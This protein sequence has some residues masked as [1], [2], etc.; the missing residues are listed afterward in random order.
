MAN[1]IIVKN[2]NETY[3]LFDELLKIRI[4]NQKYL[5]I[6]ILDDHFF[7][8]YRKKEFYILGKE[9]GNL[10]YKSHKRNS[11]SIS[12]YS[13]SIIISYA[14]NN[15]K[16]I[17]SP[18]GK[19]TKYP[20]RNY[21][22]L[23]IELDDG[24]YNFILDISNLRVKDLSVFWNTKNNIHSTKKYFFQAIPIGAK[25]IQH[26]IKS[27]GKYSLLNY[28]FEELENHIIS[29]S[30]FDHV[31]DGLYKFKTENG[32]HLLNTIDIL[33]INGNIEEIRIVD[34]LNLIVTKHNNYFQLRDTTG[35]SLIRTDD[36]QNID[37]TISE[38]RIV[39]KLN[40]I[41]T[42]HNNYFQLR[43][44]TG[45]S[46]I[47]T[48]D[49]QNI[50]KTISEIRIVD[51]L[52]RIITRHENIFRLRDY[53]GKLITQ[54]S[55]TYFDEFVCGASYA[56]TE[57]K[58]G[59]IDYNGNW[60]KRYDNPER[61]SDINKF[62]K[63]NIT[64]IKKDNL[65]GLI[66]YNSPHNINS[67]S[68]VLFAFYKNYSVIKIDGLY[69]LIDKNLKIVLDPQFEILSNDNIHV[70]TTVLYYEDHSMSYIG[71]YPNSNNYML[72]SHKGKLLTKPIYDQIIPTENK[73]YYKFKRDNISGIVNS[74]GKE[75]IVGENEIGYFDKYDKRNWIA[76]EIMVDDFMMKYK[77]FYYDNYKYKEILLFCVL[78][79]NFKGLKD[80]K[81]NWILEPIY[82]KIQ[83][84]GIFKSLK[85]R[86]IDR[87]NIRIKVQHNKK[88]FNMN[89]YG[90]RVR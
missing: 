2:P 48:D 7:I 11:Y 88:V 38:I 15:L 56:K 45:K 27:T 87:D 86:S 13:K 4:T 68:T 18:S 50:D 22:E 6:E 37:K 44:T 72:V 67:T 8:G 70:D 89:F 34:K 5:K 64:I 33:S 81:N 28:K 39:D 43:D 57:D 3:D 25:L 12:P 23:S 9:K 80:D 14:S 1:I 42:K 74:K 52:N 58:F 63:Q 83:S 66:R 35:K 24:S 77:F 60:I 26:K 71:K 61:V 90:E 65:N 41:V 69:G 20:F 53:S 76:T 19:I 79:G 54:L 21:Y 84:V 10:F 85:K 51:K 59:L 36:N 29:D 40:L 31:L 75:I 17:I 73:F 62:L 46:L 30:P 16:K 32:Y 55:F 47:R 49:N 78:E 82:D